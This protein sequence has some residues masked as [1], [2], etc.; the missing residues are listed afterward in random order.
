MKNQAFTLIE[1]LVVVLIIGILAALA[2]PR[3]QLAVDKADFRKYQAM[4]HALTSAYEDYYLANSAAPQNFSDLS[5]SLPDDFTN[6]YT[7]KYG[8]CSSNSEMFCCI[9]KVSSQNSG[10]IN[11][12]KLD[13]SIVYI[14]S[15]IGVNNA[16][17]DQENKNSKCYALVG[18][19]S[20]N[21]F[22][23]TLGDKATKTFVVT[24]QGLKQYQRYTDII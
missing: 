8:N 16:E 22:C 13:Y 12:G 2:L 21:R 7:D 15:L 18:D 14:K 9:S 1:I 6:S 19:K 23:A 20:A 5:I 10:Y 3:Y 4:A 11:C 17:V 24:P